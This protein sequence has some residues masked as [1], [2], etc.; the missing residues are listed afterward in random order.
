MNHAAELLVTTHDPVK[1]V[2]AVVGYEAPAFLS[3]LPAIFSIAHPGSFA[4][5]AADDRSFLR[6]R[7]ITMEASDLSDGH[8]NGLVEETILEMSP[9]LRQESLL[10]LEFPGQPEALPPHEPCHECSALPCA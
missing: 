7:H 5:H 2:A 4:R 10:R 1:R 8:P 3:R 6:K 9:G